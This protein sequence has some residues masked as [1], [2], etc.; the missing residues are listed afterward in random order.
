MSLVPIA[1]CLGPGAYLCM[2]RGREEISGIRIGTVEHKVSAYADD[3]LFY[4][5]D[6]RASLDTLMLEVD[7]YGL[8]SDF[9]INFREICA[10]ADSCAT[11]AGNFPAKLLSFY[12]AFRL[13]NESGSVYYS[14]FKALI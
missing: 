6:P 4:L 14:K 12:L 2:V 13:F 5:S 11:G 8:M 7:R 3:L 10:P 1:V 9:K